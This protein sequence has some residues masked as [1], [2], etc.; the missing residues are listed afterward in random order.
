[1]SRLACSPVSAI[2]WYEAF[3]R[4][5]QSARNRADGMVGL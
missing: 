5:R 1:L 4:T 3:Q 2:S